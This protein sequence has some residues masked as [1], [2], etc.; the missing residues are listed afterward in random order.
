LVRLGH[1]KMRP[2][3]LM[4]R[5]SSSHTRLLKHIQIMRVFGKTFIPLLK[6]ISGMG[7]GRGV[8]GWILKM[9]EKKFAF[10]ISTGKKQNSPLLAPYGK[11]LQ[12]SPSGHPLEKILPTPMISGTQY[13]NDGTKS[14]CMDAWTAHQAQYERASRKRAKSPKRHHFSLQHK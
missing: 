7:G 10:L 1:L 14:C 9:S 3:M 6:T 12:K 8:R 2:P 5:C 13:Q 11:I 4:Q